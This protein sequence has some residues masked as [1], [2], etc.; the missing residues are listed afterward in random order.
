MIVAFTGHRPDLFADPPA[1]QQAVATTLQALL[2]EHPVQRLLLGGQRGVDTWAA[3]TA[4]ALAVPF[5]LLLPASPAEFTC[6]WAAPDR[7]VLAHLLSQAETV[8][9]A[10]GYTDRNRRL[11]TEANLLVAIWT[12]TTG[13]GTAETLAFAQAAGTPVRDVRLAPSAAAAQARGRGI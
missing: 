9:V 7:A 10:N 5:T 11:A 8:T 6:E 13:G 3:Q 4:T 12:G 1:A 2:G